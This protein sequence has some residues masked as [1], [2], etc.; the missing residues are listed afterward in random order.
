MKSVLCALAAFAFT[1]GQA[2]AD[3][4]FSENFETN[5]YQLGEGATGDACCAHSINITQDIARA[6]DGAL[7]AVHNLDDPVVHDGNR[8]EI[9]FSDAFHLSRHGEYW[10]GFSTYIPSTWQFETD[11]SNWM[12]VWQ[13]HASPDLDLGENWRPPALGLY[14]DRSDWQIAIRSDSSR[15]STAESIAEKYKTVPLQLG[16]WSDWVFHVK[17]SHGADGFVDVYLDGQQVHQYRGPS[18]YNDENDPFMKMG[19]Y[20]A[21]TSAVY[22]RVVFHDEVKIGDSSSNP[23]EVSPDLPPAEC[24][25]TDLRMN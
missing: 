25:A 7:Q 11:I 16:R 14:I 6:G 10:F 21:S 5:L 15:V 8:A 17:W 12:T 18:Y 24:S 22:S 23:N 1:T 20:R 9:N 3:L 13:I 2:S 4:I 19:V